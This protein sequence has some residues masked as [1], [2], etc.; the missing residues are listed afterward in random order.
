[1]DVSENNFQT[2]VI[3]R[4]R[5]VPVVVDFWAE[6]CGP[7]RQLG[8]ALERAAAARPGTV[9]LV[10]GDVDANP[11][12]HAR[13]F[14]QLCERLQQ[15]LDRQWP[16]DDLR[17]GAQGLHEE[18][19]K[20]WIEP[21]QLESDLIERRVARLCESFAQSEHSLRLPVVERHAGQTVPVHATVIDVPV[22]AG[23]R[24]A[25]CFPS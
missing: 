24:S 15:F 9:E 2:A 3:E 22:P 1:M 18:A 14:G 4:S 25:P 16:H 17:E 21:V 19:Q 5:S 7:C 20:G 10:K 8:P 6:W 13:E 12:Q 11:D 23:Y